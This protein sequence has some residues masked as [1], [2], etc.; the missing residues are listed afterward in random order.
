[1]PAN[2]IRASSA[3]GLTLLESNV[4]VA[5]D[6]L[7]TITARFLA[8]AAGYN[9]ATFAL[10]ESW[11]VAALPT[12][13]P[14]L[15]GGPYLLTHEV[16]KENLLTIIL[17]TYVSAL[18]PPRLV[19]E[20]ATEQRS[21]S[22]SFFDGRSITLFGNESASISFDYFTTAQTISYAIIAPNL[23]EIKPVGTIGARFNVKSE[24]SYRGVFNIPIK[25]TEFITT[26]RTTIGKVARVSATARKILEQNDPVSVDRIF[27]GI[28]N[29]TNASTL[30]NPWQLRR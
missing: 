16:K 22:G 8:P 4:S 20:E 14:P 19:V 15:Q 12:G 1:M 11:P 28:G 26:S 9:P 3:Q 30:G 29:P 25:E 6:G 17:A 7:V 27:W 21:F 10:D 5:N 18:N 13:V 2:V 23:V 24:G